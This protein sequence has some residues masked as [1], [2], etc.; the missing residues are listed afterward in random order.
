MDVSFLIDE[1]EC[2]GIR[3]EIMQRSP[4]PPAIAI[5][6]P[7]RFAKTRKRVYVVRELRAAARQIDA[8]LATSN[9]T[10]LVVY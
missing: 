6:Y 8:T 7:P 4:R 10:N 2:I 3:F 5:W 1:L 9:I